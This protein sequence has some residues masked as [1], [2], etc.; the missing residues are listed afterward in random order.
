MT[1]TYGETKDP[2]EESIPL[3][4]L[5]HFPNQIEHTLEWAR[6][7]FQGLFHDQPQDLVSYLTDPTDYFT[8]LHTEG[9]SACQRK[10]LEK[11]LALSQLLND[12]VTYADIVAY[13]VKLF[14]FYFDHQICQ[15]LHTFPKDHVTSTKQLFWSGPKRAPEPIKFSYNDPLH[16]EFIRATCVLIAT[17]LHL[18]PQVDLNIIQNYARN[19][20]LDPFV[21]KLCKMDESDASIQTYGD[22]DVAILQLQTQLKALGNNLF[23]FSS[24][25]FILSLTSFFTCTHEH[26]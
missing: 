1:Q 24:K 15:L 18:P 12:K 22:D 23:C 26:A 2:A 8:R 10:R 5:R 13:A 4:T 14:T 21:P 7:L 16:L 11:V 17:I 20:P 3:C 25:F 19:V 9:S 6:D